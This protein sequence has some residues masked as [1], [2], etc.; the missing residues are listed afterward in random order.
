MSKPKLTADDIDIIVDLLTKWRGKLTWNLLVDKIGA[1]LNH[2]YTRQALNEHRT[3][4]RAFQIA[5]DR[6]RSAPTKGAQPRSEYLSPE[7]AVALER[8]ET[9]Q[10]EIA[11]LKLERN[12]FLEKFAVWIYNARN[13]GISEGE[14]N[15]N[16]PPVERHRTD[17]TNA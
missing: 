7:L 11:L 3:V 14:L 8:I 6:I 12:A 13:K 16:L 17:M 2:S 10:A 9:L 5:K 1:I 4:K 15:R